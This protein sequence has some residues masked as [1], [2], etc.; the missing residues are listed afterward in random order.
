MTATAQNMPDVSCAIPMAGRERV[1]TPGKHLVLFAVAASLILSLSTSYLSD[2]P[3]KPSLPKT[4]RDLSVQMSDGAFNLMLEPFLVDLSPG[5]DG[6]L[7]FAKVSLTLVTKQEATIDQVAE[8]QD[9]VRER[10]LLLLRALT[11]SDFQGDEA[12]A[13]VKRELRHRVNFVLDEDSISEVIIRDLV[14]Q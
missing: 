4:D 1:R 7:A 2:R 13:R 11:P 3:R 5:L 12:M 10:L 14:I 9:L 6:R 8:Q